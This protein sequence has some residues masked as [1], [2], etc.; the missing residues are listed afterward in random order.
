M[1][2]ISQNIREAIFL[3]TSEMQIIDANEAMRNMFGYRSVG[4]MHTLHVNDLFAE[5]DAATVLNEGLINDKGVDGLRVLFKRKDASGFWGQ[6]DWFPDKHHDGIRFAGIIRDITE[7][8]A[9]EKLL[10]EKTDMLYRINGELDNFIYHASHDL[11]SPITSMKGLINLHRI[12]RHE[13]SPYMEMLADCLDKLDSFIGQLT[14]FSKNMHQRVNDERLDFAKMLES[15]LLNFQN[16]E[17]FGKIKASL[18]LSTASPFFSDT[19]RINMVLKNI[20]EN[21]YNFHDM[22]KSRPEITISVATS[23][24]K[25]VI[26]IFDNGCGVPKAYVNKVFD[27]FFRASND[28]KGSGIGLYIAKEAVR[29]LCGTI[30]LKS[31]FGI[32]TSVA[33]EL[34]NSDKGRLI[35]LKNSRHRRLVK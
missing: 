11:R 33:I 27:M 3:S 1:Q 17:N 32:G 6:L 20:I 22:R 14:L 13:N 7:L 35:G 5:E 30:S 19:F 26:R 24:E 34:P 23:P 31:E 2:K 28:A 9:C 4:E 18:E 21:A 25:A 10:K 15:I 12:E 16:H 8:V 29:I